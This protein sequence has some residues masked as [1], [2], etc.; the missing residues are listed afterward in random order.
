MVDRNEK[1]CRIIRE[2]GYLGWLGRK[3]AEIYREHAHHDRLV[4]NSNQNHQ[5]S[6]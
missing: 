6:V 4:G 2:H 1:V 3:R 5:A